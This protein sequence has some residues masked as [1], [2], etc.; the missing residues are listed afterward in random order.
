[1]ALERGT[2]SIVA[3]Q[4]SRHYCSSRDKILGSP[5]TDDDKHDCQCVP[6]LSL[7][8]TYSTVSRRL[9]NTLTGKSCTSLTH[10]AAISSTTQ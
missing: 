4:N 6:E 10:I 5:A 8:I 9:F 3:V 2:A 1:M 7:T